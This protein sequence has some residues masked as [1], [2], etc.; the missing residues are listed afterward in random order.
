MKDKDRKLSL[1]NPTLK[2]LEKFKMY[3]LRQ[4]NGQTIEPEPE[5]LAKKDNGNPIYHIVPNAKNG[6]KH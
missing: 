6:L 1:A 2:Q 4:G 3:E 5:M